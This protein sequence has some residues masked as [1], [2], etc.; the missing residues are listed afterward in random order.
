MAVRF[1]SADEFVTEYAENLSVGGLFLRQGHTLEPLSIVTVQMSLPGF[2]EYEVKARVA[3]VLDEATAASYGREPGA[4]M[5]LIEV[6]DGFNEALMGYLGRLGKRRDCLVLVSESE[7][8][9]FLKSAGYRVA[10]TNL[11]IIPTQVLGEVAVL[12]LIVMKGGAAMYR[13]VI[14]ICPQKIPVIGCSLPQDADALL[15][16]LDRLLLAL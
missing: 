14:A 4:G 11:S 1:A 16:E 15:I 5:Q 8:H 9:D 12:A 13:D 3:H 6:P 7:T 10:E 2:G